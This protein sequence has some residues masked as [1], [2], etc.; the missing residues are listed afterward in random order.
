M[1]FGYVKRVVGLPG[2]NLELRSGRL[3]VD[4]SP[5][6]ESYI[7]E[8]YR[9]AENFGPVIVP[10]DHFFVLGDRRN[11]SSDS[12]VWGFVSR[13]RMRGRAYRIYWSGGD[14]RNWV[15]MGRSLSLQ[16]R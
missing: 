16:G 11:R 14:G 10:E 4:E 8:D 6:E 12:R 7:N 15:R 2:E 3:Y 9:E 13:E 1:I 5:V